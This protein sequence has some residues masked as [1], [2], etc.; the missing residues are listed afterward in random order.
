MFERARAL[1]D[2]AL[3]ATV[4]EIAAAVRVLVERGR[5]IAEGAGACSL[6]CALAGGAGDGRVVCVISGGNM[7]EAPLRAALAGRQP[8]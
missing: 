5:V 1:I 3:V 8:S 2:G 6:A 7:D 4:A